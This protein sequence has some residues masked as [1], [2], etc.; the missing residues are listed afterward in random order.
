[1]LEEIAT[2]EDTPASYP[3]NFNRKE[4]PFFF[5]VDR[6]RGGEGTNRVDVQIEVPVNPV[7]P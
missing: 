6:F 3:F 7:C 4:L 5:G 1:V 2:V